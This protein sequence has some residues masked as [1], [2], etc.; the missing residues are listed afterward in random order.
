M[1]TAHCIRFSISLRRSILSQ[2][3]DEHPF[4]ARIIR[5]ITPCKHYLFIADYLMFIS[6]TSSSTFNSDEKKNV[7][8]EFDSLQLLKH[9]VFVILHLCLLSVIDPSNRAHECEIMYAPV[10]PSMI[11]EWF[12]A[13]PN[14]RQCY[15]FAKVVWRYLYIP[16][17][18]HI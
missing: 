8:T 11:N 10:Y 18:M 1:I 13:I 17:Y 3:F 4:K 14:H 7:N 12:I 16:F 9:I 5:H 2:S 6:I 15:G